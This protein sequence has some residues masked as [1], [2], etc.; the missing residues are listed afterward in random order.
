M[1]DRAPAGVDGSLVDDGASDA[2]GDAT[3]IVVILKNV[4]KVGEQNVSKA[5]RK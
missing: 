4:S 2:T 1:R 5:E 3:G